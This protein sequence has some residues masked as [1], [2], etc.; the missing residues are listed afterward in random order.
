MGVTIATEGRSHHR[1]VMALVLVDH[2]LRWRGQVG[3]VVKNVVANHTEK[4]W[5]SLDA[6]ASWDFANEGVIRH[7][8]HLYLW[9]VVPDPTGE[10]WYMPTCGH[11]VLRN[12]FTA[13]E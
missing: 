11:G 7:G 8:A 12:S 13:A 9:A 10:T 1:A 6:G 2:W 4:V 5:I 3:V